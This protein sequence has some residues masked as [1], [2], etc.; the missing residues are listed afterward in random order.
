MT[1][2]QTTIKRTLVLMAAVVAV[3]VAA[4]FSMAAK[5]AHASATYTVRS[6]GDA[7]DVN[8]GDSLCDA[9]P[10]SSVIQCTLRA[11]IMQANNQPGP[12]TINFD[13]PGG[14]AYH[15]IS[16]NSLLPAITDQVTIN[17]YSQPGASPNTLAKG[18]DAVL[19]IELNGSS[20]AGNV[21]GLDVEA[22]N[23][24]VRG[25]VIN[26]FN[27]SGIHIQDVADNTRVEGNFIGT[28]PSGT[29]G[30]GNGGYGVNIVGAT[31]VIVGGAAPDKRN[32]ISGNGQ[33]GVWMIGGSLSAVLGNYI[34]TQKDGIGS[35]GN[36]RYG[37]FISGSS[38]NNVG[39]LDSKSNTIAF[40]SLDGVM[41]QEAGQAGG[42]ANNNLVMR[43]SIYAN[44]GKGITL[45]SSGAPLPN[46]AGDA[47]VGPN[48]LQNFPV[49]T[50]ARVSRK[51]TTVRGTLNSTSGTSF[52][53]EF[54]S[55][56]SGTDAEGKTFIG[57]KLV[58]TDAAGNVSFS[59]K[60]QVKVRGGTITATATNAS[61]SDTSEF[62]APRKVRRV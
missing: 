8:I 15:T 56:P 21:T 30:L 34:G 37:V 17:G 16:P 31:N 14:A 4:S 50:S 24:V 32:V 7:G 60:P 35:L 40:N 6:T 28:D 3:L 5:P 51:A 48:N 25:L 36:A 23:T 11:A 19:K 55:N 33:D 41:I 52:S 29:Q 12:D 26:R 59:F 54:F 46:D 53:I 43:N 27:N 61:T 49:L 22:E 42:N 10:D 18:N 20:A 58:T 13:L 1:I 57:E 2:T 44:G 9:H 39:G 47:D 45:D 38:F 62:S